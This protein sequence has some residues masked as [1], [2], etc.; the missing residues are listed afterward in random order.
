MLVINNGLIRHDNYWTLLW[1]ESAARIIDLGGILPAP[2]Y[3][4]FNA[5]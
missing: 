2:F 5:F 3:G 4:L 1:L